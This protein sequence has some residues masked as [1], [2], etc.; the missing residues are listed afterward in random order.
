MTE[1]V[2]YILSLIFLYISLCCQPAQALVLD[3]LYRVE[4]V[5]VGQGPDAMRGVAAEALREVLV[6]VSGSRGV[7]RD[8][9]VRA[10]LA[11]ADSF[12]I[13]YGYGEQRYTE[14]GNLGQLLRLDFDQRAVAELLRASG[15]PIWSAQRP[16]VLVWLALDGSNGLEFVSL[17]TTPALVQELTQAFASRGVPVIFPLFDLQDEMLVAPSDVVQ[18]DESRLLPAAQRYAAP[19]LLF[20]RILQLSSGEL[21][22]DWIYRQH[23]AELSLSGEAVDLAGLF[24]RAVDRIAATLAAEYAIT[25]HRY[26]ED[27]LLLYVEGVDGFEEYAHLVQSLEAIEAVTHANIDRV[28]GNSVYLR[29]VAEG[30][31]QQL[32]LAIGLAADLHRLP[33]GHPARR[34][35]KLP[36]NLFYS[37]DG[38]GDISR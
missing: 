24:E 31:L 27:G 23:S 6:R 11:R 30:S 28:D 10:A 36:V 2:K 17:D 4:R 25:P 37:L 7:L 15:L 34:L 1:T 26:F 8:A 5:V 9:A 20:G 18:F 32:E 21:V 35:H 38:Y 3:N 12:I 14:E 19:A 13:Q 33:D 22:G 16:A 29:L